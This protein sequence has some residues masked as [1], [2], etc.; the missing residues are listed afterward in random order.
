MPE[1]D[2]YSGLPETPR[3]SRRQKTRWQTQD[4][5]YLLASPLVAGRVYAAILDCPSTCDE[6][7]QRLGGTHQSISAAVNA[8]MREGWIVP[9]GCRR[10]TRSGREAIVWKGVRS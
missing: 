1:P 6:V 10:P 3:R 9:T 8:L 4:A 2:L 7:E 5:A